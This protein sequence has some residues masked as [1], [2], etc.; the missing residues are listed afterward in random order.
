MILCVAFGVHC[1]KSAVLH[2]C[3]YCV[4]ADVI[5]KVCRVYGAQLCETL[6]T[7]CWMLS[8]LFAEFF[9]RGASSKVNARVS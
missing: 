5:G 8:F 3:F 2:A 6:S 1:G 7:L 4:L 9:G